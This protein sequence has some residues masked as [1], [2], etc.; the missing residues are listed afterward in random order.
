MA[1][2]IKSQWLQRTVLRAASLL[3][4]GDRRA[5][6]LEGWRSELWYVPPRGAT[7]FC[8][9]AFR[10]AFWLR[11]NSLSPMMLRL[12][13]PLACLSFLA[14]LAAASSLMAVCLPGPHTMTRSGHLSARDLPAGCAAMLLVSW[15]FFAAIRVAMGRAAAQ[16]QPVPWHG[17]LRLGIFLALKIALVQP[18][19]LCGFVAAAAVPGGSLALWAW[20][21][22]PCHWV[23]A[24]Q[25]RRCPVC[26]RLLTSPVRIG[27]PSQTFLEW[28]GAE[29]TCSR[30]HGL[31]H[32]A[33][34]PASYSGKPQWLRLG[35]S[36]SGLF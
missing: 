7:R 2:L 24:D 35:D 17:R 19:L 28:Y 21:A 1:A 16:P 12:E 29:S 5:E 13:S 9:G 34:T 30:G 26:P 25:R 23:L 32:V 11:R 6:W 8:L 22:V 14:A 27:T 18:I 10:D 15:V 31:L 20:W 36:W 3:A 33:E 4:P